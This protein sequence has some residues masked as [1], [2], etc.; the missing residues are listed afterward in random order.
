MKP[1]YNGQNLRDLESS[2]VNHQPATGY[3]NHLGE[4]TTH[5]RIPLDSADTQIILPYIYIYVFIY[6]YMMMI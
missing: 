4:S 3:E 1:G 2:H 6:I 5:D